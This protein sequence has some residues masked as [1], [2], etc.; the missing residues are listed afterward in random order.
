MVVVV[1]VV[2]VVEKEACSMALLAVWSRVGKS[3]ALLSAWLKGITIL[4]PS[5]LE[6]YVYTWSALLR[7]EWAIL[8]CA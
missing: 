2:V 8:R 7:L 4:G 6:R 1:V 5:S 3:M